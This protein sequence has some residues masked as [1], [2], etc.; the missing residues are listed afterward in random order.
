MEINTNNFSNVGFSK[1]QDVQGLHPN[2]F[3][4]SRKVPAREMCSLNY[5]LVN[6]F[7]TEAL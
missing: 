5:L 4:R 6:M 7:D 1:I 3:E 2:I